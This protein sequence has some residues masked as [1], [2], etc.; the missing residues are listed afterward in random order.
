MKMRMQIHAQR[1][2]AFMRVVNAPPYDDPLIDRLRLCYAIMVY[3]HESDFTYE[4]HRRRR[5]KIDLLQSQVDAE[6][7]RLKA[8]ETAQARLI[9]KVH[10]AKGGGDVTNS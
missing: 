1:I 3:C 6:I 4:G 5:G 8:A 10:N 7:A 9:K 2:D